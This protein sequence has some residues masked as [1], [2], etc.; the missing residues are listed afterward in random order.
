MYWVLNLKLTNV[1]WSHTL[2][3]YESSSFRSRF[4]II[5]TF[6]QFLE[7][8]FFLL[9]KVWGLT[10]SADGSAYIHDLANPK[11]GAQWCSQLFDVNLVH[12][13]SGP[14]FLESTDGHVM[15]SEWHDV[16]F[17]MEA[18]CYCS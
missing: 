4:S 6:C 12:F 8:S 16:V 3:Y 11:V 1:F 2:Q 15:L 14:T 5:H 17:G 9:L 13:N 10:L 18:F 7:V